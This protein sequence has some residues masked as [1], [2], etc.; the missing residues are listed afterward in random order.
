MMGLVDD[1]HRQLFGFRHQ[2]GDLVA[3]GLACGGAGALDGQAEFPCDLL[4]D[5]EHVAGGQRDVVDAIETGVESCGEVSADGCL[6][7]SHLAG[8]QADAAQVDEMAEAGLGLAAGRG[9]EQFVGLGRGLEGQAC[10][11][12]VLAVHHSSSF[13]SV[14]LRRVSGEGGGSGGGWS[15]WIS[16]VDQV[17]LTAVLA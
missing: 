10:E 14:R 2:T 3:D 6:A 1:Q 7:G 17:R 16:L 15:A 11:G 9:V 4:V 12:E 8:E 5:V 13:L